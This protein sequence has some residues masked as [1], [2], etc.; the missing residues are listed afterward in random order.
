MSVWV[1]GRSI[2]YQTDLSWLAIIG[3]RRADQ[4]D[5]TSFVVWLCGLVLGH[6][7]EQLANEI[8]SASKVDVQY[9]VNGRQRERLV[10][11]INHLRVVSI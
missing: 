4:D 9:K 2:T 11:T 8:Q 10:V 1:D 6:E 5:T 3:S 7:W